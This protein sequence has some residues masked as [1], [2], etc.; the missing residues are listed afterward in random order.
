MTTL[1]QTDKNIREGFHHGGDTRES[2]G[3]RAPSRCHHKWLCHEKHSGHERQ[4]RSCYAGRWWCYPRWPC[5]CFLRLAC[6][7]SASFWIYLTCRIR[8][9]DRKLSAHRRRRPCSNLLP[10]M[11]RRSTNASLASESSY[12]GYGDQGFGYA[13]SPSSSSGYENG[14]AT[15]GLGVRAATAIT[16]LNNNNQFLLNCLQTA[17]TTNQGAS[18]FTEVT[19]ILVL[20]Y[21]SGAM[22]RSGYATTA[23]INTPSTGSI[24]SLTADRAPLPEFRAHQAS[25]IQAY[26]SPTGVSPAYPGPR[27]SH[28]NPGLGHDGFESS[29]IGGRTIPST[30]MRRKA[31]GSSLRWISPIASRRV[32]APLHPDTSG[33]AARAS[34]NFSYYSGSHPYDHPGLSAWHGS[35]WSE[36][37]HAANRDQRERPISYVHF[38][39]CMHPC[40]VSNIT[41]GSLSVAAFCF[42]YPVPDLW[43]SY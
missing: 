35:K 26:R 28:G 37:L 27:Y 30:V 43:C 31:I 23:P 29:F 33:H 39:Y 15:G 8:R 34:R 11:P 7:C 9:S 10:G 22:M 21:N 6:N 32:T 3:V 17:T 12:R 2:F 19:V 40:H 36:L 41:T 20:V 4:H 14:T 24:D 18:G 38:L 16:S 42:F 5:F 1:N 25:D 13:A